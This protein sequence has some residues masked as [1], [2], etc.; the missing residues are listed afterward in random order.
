MGFTKKNDTST[1]DRKHD[2]KLK[3]AVNSIQ[4]TVL[5]TRLAPTSQLRSW[6]IVPYDGDNLY[7]NKIKAVAQRSNT[8][9]SAA[10][11]LSKFITGDGISDEGI[12][13]TSEEGI[14]AFP[15]NSEGDTIFDILRFTS[16]TRSIFNGMVLHVN[17]NILGEVMEINQVNFEF[18]RRSSDRKTFISNPDWQHR[19]KELDVE[20]FPFNPDTA[21]N[22]IQEVGIENYN[23]QLCYW[24]PSKSDDYTTCTFDASMD[25]SQLEAEV[26]LYSLSDVQNGYSVGGIYRVPKQF[27]GD[28]EMQSFIRQV[29]S[30]SGSENANR[31]LV[32]SIP[33]TDETKDWKMFEPTQRTD[34]DTMFTNQIENARFNIYSVYN[35]PPILNGISKNGMFNAESYVDA[36]DY[37]NSQ[38]KTMRMEAERFLNK[39]WGASIWAEMGK[40]VITPSTFERVR[41]ENNTGN[42]DT[43]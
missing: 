16:G 3:V 34:I 5:V 35:Q 21:V 27:E 18:I 32:V 30:G 28:E 8:T 40:L 13:S 26:K 43:E 31:T 2:R 19:K 17:Y 10:R 20:Y 33:A 11:T 36:F 23:G 7:P 1:F 9:T 41:D 15:V 29:E 42:G 39:I 12:N 38:T 22:E 37:Y 24:I 25:D 6:D 4:R 14:N